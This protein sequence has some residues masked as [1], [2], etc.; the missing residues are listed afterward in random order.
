[1]FL[2]D[3]FNTFGH[4]V[5]SIGRA[6]VGKEASGLL[7]LLS[8]SEMLEMTTFQLMNACGFKPQLLSFFNTGLLGARL[9]QTSLVCF[10]MS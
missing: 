8:P 10:L 3:L 5:G 9:R 6:F 4:T 7:F 1:M 2:S